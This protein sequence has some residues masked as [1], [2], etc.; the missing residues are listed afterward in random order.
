MAP[1]RSSDVDPTV[2]EGDAPSP[3]AG[4]ALP[5]GS[6][7]YRIAI[8]LAMILLAVAAI[9]VGLYLAGKVS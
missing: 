9:F 1:Q 7:G 2:N 8:M 4:E 5:E 3:D 6:V